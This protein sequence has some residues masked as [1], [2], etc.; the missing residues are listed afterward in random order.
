MQERRE[1]VRESESGPGELPLLA[2]WLAL[3]KLVIL[4]FLFSFA[5]YGFCHD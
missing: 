3:T 4:L 1:D 2:Q 5:G